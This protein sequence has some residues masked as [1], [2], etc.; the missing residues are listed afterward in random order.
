MV[1]GRGVVQTDVHRDRRL[2]LGIDPKEDLSEAQRG[3]LPLE[4]GGEFAGGT[5]AAE[6]RV[7]PQAQQFGAQFVRRIAVKGA[8]AEEGPLQLRDREQAVP[9][10]LAIEV[11]LRV[12]SGRMRLAGM[13]RVQIVGCAQ[14]DGDLISTHANSENRGVRGTR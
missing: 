12:P 6:F 2:I 1:S 14:P 10:D 4:E 3:S 5:L 11:A 9:G 7:D 13:Q 8:T